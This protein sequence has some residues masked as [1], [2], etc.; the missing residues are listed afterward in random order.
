MRLSSLL[1]IAL[2]GVGSVAQATC[3]EDRITVHGDWGQA[4]FTIEVADE[5][6]ER[7]QGLMFVESMGVMEGMLFV[8]ERPRQA[9]FWMRNTLI[10]LDMIFAGPDGTVLHVHENAVPMSEE[11]IDGGDGVVFTL[12][13]NGGMAAR[14]GIAP[15]DVLQHPSIGPDA[16][17]PCEE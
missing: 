16:A 15:G 11:T 7:Q 3:R 14:L 2:I 8:Y 9:T 17:L 13:I 12:E 4:S 10:A 6:A 1:A 5:P